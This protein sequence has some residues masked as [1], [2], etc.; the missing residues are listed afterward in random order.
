[1]LSQSDVNVELNKEID[2]GNRYNNFI[3]EINYKEKVLMKKETF[4]Q[5]KI[6]RQLVSVVMLG[7]LLTPVAL[8]SASTVLAEDKAV[9]SL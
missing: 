1:M 2:R 4:S 5:R 3:H 7:L 6:G 9:Q 8:Q